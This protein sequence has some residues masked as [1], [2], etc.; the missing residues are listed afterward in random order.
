MLA[1]IV[2]K[3]VFLSTAILPQLTKARWASSFPPVSTAIYT[4]YLPLLLFCAP[5]GYWMQVEEKGATAGRAK[6]A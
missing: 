1:Q 4:A 5:W 3:V 6:V 2:Y